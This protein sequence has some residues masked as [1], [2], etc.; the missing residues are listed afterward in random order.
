[1]GLSKM[2][3]KSFKASKSCDN[4]C[5][6]YLDNPGRLDGCICE[7]H[8]FEI[9]NS[10]SSICDNYEDYAEEGGRGCMITYQDYIN[11]IVLGKVSKM[12]DTSFPNI[13]HGAVGLC[14]E[15]GELLDAFAT[16]D[17]I[18]IKEELGDVLWYLTLIFSELS[19]SI[20]IYQ[21]DVRGLVHG[22]SV[23]SQ[24]VRYE[25]I[26]VRR[27]SQLLDVVKKGVFYGKGLDRAV[28]YDQLCRCHAI[29]AAIARD[30]CNCTM[31]EIMRLNTEK[32]RKRYAKNFT[33][34]EAHERNLDE[35]RKALELG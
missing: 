2:K 35:E 25:D 20:N 11:E 22:T 6:H 27:S 13:V 12:M 16:G 15:A 5:R 21:Y 8:D 4:F 3:P 10:D 29:V 33:T 9:G 18:N 32:L 28:L 34:G 30:V 17:I 24:S 7:L 31:D 1:M 14:T 19:I 23:L 26:F